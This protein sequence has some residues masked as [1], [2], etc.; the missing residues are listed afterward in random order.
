MWKLLYHCPSLMRSLDGAFQQCLTSMDYPQMLGGFHKCLA[1]LHHLLILHLVQVPPFLHHFLTP[2]FFQSKFCWY[3]V[4]PAVISWPE[5]VE[6]NTSSD[7]FNQRSVFC[8]AATT[9]CQS[10]YTLLDNGR[11]EALWEPCQ[12]KFISWEGCAF[13]WGIKGQFSIQ[14]P[15]NQQKN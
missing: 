6:Q 11:R 15:E 2:P 8:Q 13:A 1:C 7:M 10:P 9:I 14:G 5:D 12:P 3:A 4:V